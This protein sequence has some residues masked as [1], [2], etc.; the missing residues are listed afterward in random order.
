M[1]REIESVHLTCDLEL[2]EHKSGSITISE[3][4][5]DSDINE[6]R[7]IEY[8]SG[9]DE[10]EKDKKKKKTFWKSIFS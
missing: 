3:I 6:P 5:D 7:H 2:N 1:Y 4:K 9:Q 8:I 10:I